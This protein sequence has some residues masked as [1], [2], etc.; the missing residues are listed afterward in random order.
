MSFDQ[1]SFDLYKQHS[2]N[3]DKNFIQ[4]KRKPHARDWQPFRLAVRDQVI[5]LLVLRH[6]TK[7][8]IIEVDVFMTEDPSYIKGYGGTKMAMLFILSTAYKCG[9]TM[10]IKF[11]KNVEEGTVPT[12]LIEMADNFGIELK[13]ILEGFVTPKES[14]MLYLAL[15]GFSTEVIR[16]IKELSITNIITPERICY[17]IHHNVWKLEEME[18]IILGCEHPEWV[19]DGTVDICDYLKYFHAIS[20]A[21][22]AILGGFIDQKLRLKEIFDD[23]GQAIDVEANDRQFDISFDPNF[24]AKV[25]LTKEETPIPWTVDKTK[26]VS[27]NER[28]VIAIRGYDWP[29][30]CLNFERD[31]Q[32]F[33]EM[34]LGYRDNIPTHFFVLIPRDIIYL[35]E[36]MNLDDYRMRLQKDGITLMVCP[37]LVVMLDDDAQKRFQKETTMRHD[38][39]TGESSKRNVVISKAKSIYNSPELTLVT[40]ATDTKYGVVDLPKLVEQ[41]L[42]DETELYNKVNRSNV[43]S[44]YH[45]CLDRIAH[46]GKVSLLNQTA[47]KLVV[48]KGFLE[49]LLRLNLTKMVYTN[50]ILDEFIG[51]LKSFQISVENSFFLLSLNSFLEM[52]KK[53]GQTVILILDMFTK[54]TDSSVVVP[55]END[56]LEATF[57]GQFVLDRVI[58]YSDKNPFKVAEQMVWNGVNRSKLGQA[59][60]VNLGELPHALIA[61]ILN[62]FLYMKITDSDF[63]ISINIVY[64]DGSKAR[65]FPLC[66]LK[67]RT[68]EEMK[69]ICQLT[70]IKIGMMSCRH[71]GM[72]ELIDRYWFRNIE[73][74]MAGRSTAEKD[75]FAYQTTKSKLAEILKFKNPVRIAFYQT[76]FEPIAIGFYRALAEFLIETSGLT[77][78]IE[79]VPYFY[80]KNTGTYNAGPFWS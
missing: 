49:E 73:I 14:R 30:F 39:A 28:L 31:R 25:Y 19:L 40:V 71:E 54:N 15:T 47:Q 46:V 75:E 17:M 7:E 2:F 37:E 4:A 67:K 59:N 21:R 74:N 45:R 55:I 70:P 61:Q 53:N 3:F 65:T 77:P 64:T 18:S 32:A 23:N 24:F 60:A 43:E 68:A 66:R 51:Q 26:A 69:S 42:Y 16:R 63:P 9:S 22:S 76:G 52:A 72:D 34:K 41:S 80:N 44:R 36:N 5:G 10:G 13:Y 62:Y 12:N 27:P 29:D 48:P 8:N 35:S 78:Q 38:V 6:Q 11:T 58:D 1:K 33:Q 20:T 79:V 56:Q 50:N 57:K